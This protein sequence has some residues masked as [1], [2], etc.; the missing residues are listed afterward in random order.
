MEAIE[1]EKAMSQI[2]VSYGDAI[3]AGYGKIHAEGM[4]VEAAAQELVRDIE[5]YLEGVAKDAPSCCIDGRD[6][7]TC[8]DDEPTEPRPGIAGGALVTAY[9]AAELVGWFA[10]DAGSSTD[11]LQTV[12]DHLDAVIDDQTGKPTIVTGGHCDQSA[13]ATAFE[14]KTGCG[15]GDR[16]P[17]ILIQRHEN[18]KAINSFV[19]LVLD[20]RFDSSDTEV[21]DQETLA[22]RHAD[23]TPKDF[24]EVIGGTENGKHKVEILTSDPQ[25]ETHGH[26]ELAVVFNDVEN[27]TVDRDRLVRETGKQ[28]FDV[29][30][31]YLRKLAKVMAVGP[32]AETQERQLLHAMVAYQIATY[33]T[34]CD[35]SQR[36]IFIRPET[37]VAA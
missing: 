5:G 18:S 34:L 29:D 32:N 21:V 30:L 6:C 14:E 23:W 35:G 9:A 4:D 15:A 36:P 8:M 12:Q 1:E 26:A 16:L 22:A 2:R 28:V 11:R 31:W 3:S 24:I 27:T 33:L 19:E 13:V 20:E 25:S 10:P 37:T 7:V 17:E